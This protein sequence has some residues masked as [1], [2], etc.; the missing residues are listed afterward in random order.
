MRTL[1]QATKPIRTF[2][3]KFPMLGVDHIFVNGALQPL[4]VTVHRSPLARVASDHFPL[5]AEFV[6]SPAPYAK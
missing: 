2:P 5:V 4:S 3:T 6:L 1:I